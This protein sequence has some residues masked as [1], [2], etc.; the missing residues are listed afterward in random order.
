M[1]SLNLT[2]AK[3]RLTCLT[4]STYI[5]QNRTK[6]K[7]SDI[8]YSIPFKGHQDVAVLTYFDLDHYYLKDDI[9]F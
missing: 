7:L 4:I 5:I 2:T 8:S 1:N 9:S 6:F 3:N